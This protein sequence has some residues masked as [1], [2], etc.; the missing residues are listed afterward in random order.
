MTIRSAKTRSLLA[1][2][3]FEGLAP[4]EPRRMMDAAGFAPADIDLNHITRLDGAAEWS[5]ADDGDYGAGLDESAD[6]PGSD[7]DIYC[8]TTRGAAVR[9][10]DDDASDEA[11]S[12]EDIYN[13]GQDRGEQIDDDSAYETGDVAPIVETPLYTVPTEE[14]V[15]VAAEGP[16]VV[17]ADG[18]ESGAAIAPI[19]IL[20]GAGRAS[21]AG[22]G[23]AQSGSSVQAVEGGSAPATW[24]DLADLPQP[25]LVIQP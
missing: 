20:P 18:E 14:S 21:W 25:S 2:A 22:E 13:F 9:M 12:D 7:A 10:T 1:H 5:D 15:V 16:V 23:D 4:L 8:F 6:Q 24:T 19:A 17:V 11:G 3:P